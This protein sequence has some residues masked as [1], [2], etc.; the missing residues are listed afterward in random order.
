MRDTRPI[1]RHFALQVLGGLALLGAP[2]ARV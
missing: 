2:R 1:I